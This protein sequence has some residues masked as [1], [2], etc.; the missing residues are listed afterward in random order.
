MRVPIEWLNEFVT[1][2]AT[3][4][5]IATRLTMGGLEVEGN[6]PA[7]EVYAQAIKK[8]VSEEAARAAEA[9]GNVLSV[10]IT[11]NRGDC[12]SLVGV[13]R[14]VGALFGSPL[15]HVSPPPSQ[16]GGA[17]DAATS[18]TVE[19]TALCPRY[20]ARVVRG[21]RV[22]PS[23]LWMQARLAAT[24]Q[25]PINNV[26]D[27][28]N[29]VMLEM[30][31]PLH[32]FDLNRL[33][34]NRI[35]VRTARE[36]EILTTLD[37]VE[38]ALKPEMLVIADAERP[39]ALA[40][41]MGGAE[42]EVF[43][44]TTDILL[45]LAHFDPLS[46][47]RTAKAFGMS[48]EASYRFE[49]VVDPDGVRR[50][51]DRAC[52]L[53]EAMG[54]PAAVEGAIDIYPAPVEPRPLCLR[55]DRLNDLL[56]MEIASHAAADCLRALDFDVRTESDGATDVLSVHTPT[57]R[58]DITMEEDLV[59]EVGRIYGY[60]NIPET[61]P[62]GNTTQGGDSAF[63]IFLG[64]V[65]AS[66]VSCGL[67]EVV[68][69]SLSAPSFFN[70][71]DDAAR[72]VA[73]RNALSAEV[74]GLRRSLLPSL[75]DVAQRNANRGTHDVAIF[76]AG[77]VWQT[78]SDG[79]RPIEY[80]SIGGL[81]TGAVSEKSWYRD[82]KPLVADYGVVRGV[83]ERLLHDLD[84]TGYEIEPPADRAPSLPQFHPGRSAIV[85]LAGEMIGVIGEAHP[86]FASKLDLRDRAY[87]FELSS[88]ALQASCR[89]A[90]LR[91]RPLPSSP[92]VYRDLAPRVAADLPYRAVEQAIRSVALP[93][94][95]SLRLI[96]VFQGAPLPEGT[97]SLTLAFTF[98]DP[99]RTLTEAEI[100]DAIAMLRAALEQ[101][102]AA[103]FQ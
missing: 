5:E 32:A 85:T 97:R 55:I 46:V 1:V 49:R 4:E 101:Q 12:L 16:L 59:E 48:T 26:V 92:A 72:R 75:I 22:G 38:R 2:D 88:E 33:A 3:A 29:Y 61:L 17:I 81:L 54:Q 87:L 70:S 30:G 90:S 76:G 42:S 10:Y 35:V 44:A 28:T 68:T 77:R 62:L 41:V 89:N 74:S 27:V 60:E 36:G 43:E 50:A 63:G 56:G 84:I 80:V 57:F 11:P 31:Q 65:R 95:E 24:G 19:D 13:A 82:P 47:R 7:E 96:D 53:L 51:L 99:A 20:A 45:E 52:Q 69:H 73:V 23:P 71:P 6:E 91:Y 40:G 37:G 58:A 25:R 64:R 103:K 8:Q 100:N 93:I 102:C 94:L 15:R 86:R 79:G 78:D 9:L 14:E 98:R 18:V 21:I 39:I 83:V 67:Q 34:E 66:L